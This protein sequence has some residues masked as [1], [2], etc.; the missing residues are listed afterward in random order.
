MLGV[1]QKATR[2]AAAAP[3]ITPSIAAIEGMLA[4]LT[5]SAAPSATAADAENGGAGGGGLLDNSSGSPGGRAW[6]ILLATP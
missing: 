5:G 6:Q 4:E 2:E 3:R 1:I